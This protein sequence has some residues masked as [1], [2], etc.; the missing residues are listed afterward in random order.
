M[1]KPP[2]VGDVI[3]EMFGSVV[4]TPKRQ[5]R[6]RSSTFW[7]KFGFKMRTK[8]R[9]QQVWAAIQQRGLVLNLDQA[10][11]GTEDKDEWITLSYLDPT[12]PTITVVQPDMPLE[13]IPTPDAAWFELIAKRVF[14]SER[15]VEYYFIVPLLEKLG[16]VEDDFA[17]GYPVQM[18]EGV[19]KVNKE[20]DFVM[21]NGLSRGKGDALLIVEAK[22]TEKIITEDAIG[23]ARAYA[24]WLT[25]PYYLVTN[26]D[27]IRL[28]LFRGAVQTDILLLN[29]TRAEL[30]Q[31]WRA[32]YH[33]LNKPAVIEYKQ[34]LDKVLNSDHTTPH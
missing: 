31:N 34:H 20:A 19:R 5:R 26:G 7:E 8:E 9:V 32:L 27:T 33:T 24:M 1:A 13:E 15:E 11:F 17:I 29:F 25:T 28:Y 21:F 14:E 12:P 30:P 2:A 16:F 23:Q 18:Y 22:K 4:A 3:E 6:L 10:T